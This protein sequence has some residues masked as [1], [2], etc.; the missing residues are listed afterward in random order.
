MNS[1]RK[2]IDSFRDKIKERNADSIYGNQFIYNS[3]MEQ[4]KW[5][6]KREI[7]AGRIYTNTSSFQILRC[8]EVIEVP[9]TDVCCPVKTNCKVYR[10]KHKLPELWIDN[11]GPVIK[12]VTSIDASTEFV[13][14][15]PKNWETKKNDPYQ[16]MMPTKY[17]M[18]S[19]G[20]LYFLEFN[21]HRV[22]ITGFY[23]DDIEDQ[24][25]C[26]ENKGCIKFLDKKFMIPDW[27]EAEMYAKALQILFPVKQYPTD[28]QID[29]NTNRKN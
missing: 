10:T 11:K 8:F 12:S 9:I 27:V 17:V 1:K 16:K 26:V 24:N 19:E 18:Y 4:A 5:L 15:D 7:S 22:N 25:G 14:I 6:I 21:P 23:K 13:M 2:T 20:Y 3:L 28:E 29:K